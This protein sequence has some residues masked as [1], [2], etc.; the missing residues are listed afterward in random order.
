MSPEVREHSGAGVRTQVQ[1]TA[2]HLVEQTPSS[3]TEQ[4]GHG[5][6]H[7]FFGEDGMDLALRFDRRW[8]SLARYLSRSGKV[9]RLPIG[10]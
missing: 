9:V 3:H 10:P 5:H 2:V 7:P 8:T 1:L 6:R 4:V